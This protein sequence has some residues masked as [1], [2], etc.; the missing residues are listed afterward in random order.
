MVM[1]MFSPS[2]MPSAMPVSHSGKPG[3]PS[4]CSWQAATAACR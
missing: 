1:R 3:M 2:I 4:G